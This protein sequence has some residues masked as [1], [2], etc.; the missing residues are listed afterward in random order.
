MF[1]ELD[2]VVIKSYKR[3]VAMPDQQP[4]QPSPAPILI[5]LLP[6]LYASSKFHGALP[7]SAPH[8]SELPNLSSAVVAL[9]RGLISAGDHVLPSPSLGT[10]I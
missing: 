6:L 9:P 3:L 8:V 1:F 10:R 7:A 2:R 4:S 5:E